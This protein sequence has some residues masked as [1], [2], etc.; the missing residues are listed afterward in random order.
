MELRFARRRFLCL[1]TAFLF[2]IG[3][4]A[5]AWAVSDA[6]LKMP[7]AEMSGQDHGMDCGGGDDKAAHAACVAMCASGVAILSA[8]VA[9]PL[10]VA[11]ADR[12]FDPELPL[13][14][15][16]PSPEPHPP[17]R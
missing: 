4:V 9:I 5:H 15:R 10:A 17:K 3:A 8:P 16:G 6:A 7:A 2:G 14:G 1:L 12:A 11:M 13:P